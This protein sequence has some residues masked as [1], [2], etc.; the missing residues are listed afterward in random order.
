MSDKHSLR[1]IETLVLVGIGG[2]AG[3]NLR[4]FVDSL[5]PGLQGTLLVNTLGSFLLGFILYEAIYT[6]QFTAEARTILGTGFLASFT[7][8]STFILETF[9]TPKWALLNIIASYVLGFTGVLIG[10]TLAQQVK[11]DEI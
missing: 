9:Q 6:N 2:F 3:S 7:T 10:R 8:Y 4:Y 11:R 5:L 1:H